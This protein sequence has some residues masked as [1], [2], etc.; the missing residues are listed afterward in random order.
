MSIISAVALLMTG[1]GPSLKSQCQT[2]GNTHNKN[3]QNV[4]SLRSAG[5]LVYDHSVE[6]QMASSW[7]DSAKQLA[8]LDISDSKLKKIQGDL[9]AAHQHAG[10]LTSQSAALIPTHNQV[11]DTLGDQIDQVRNGAMENMPAA[12]QAL[13]LHCTGR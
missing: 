9:V 6:K 4:L 2:L 12:F 13:T 3:F 11:N 1:C 10:E 5:S 8:K 7:T